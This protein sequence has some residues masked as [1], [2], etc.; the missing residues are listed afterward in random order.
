MLIAIAAHLCFGIF[1]LPSLLLL[2]DIDRKELERIA[3]AREETQEQLKQQQKEMRVRV[4][5]EELPQPEEREKPEEEKKEERAEKVDLDK[6]VVEQVTNEET[7][8]D[9]EFVSMEANKVDEE[10]RARETTLKQVLPGNEMP[11]EIEDTGSPDPDVERDSKDE[12]PAEASEQLAA[13]VP[14]QS[15]SPT[16][17]QAERRVEKDVTQKPDETTPKKVTEDGAYKV[18]EESSPVVKQESKDG[19]R[20]KVDPRKLFGPPSE[21][22]YER[23]FGE[24][25]PKPKSDGSGEKRRRLFSDYA[26]KQKKIRASLENMIPEIQPGNHTAV[27]AD[28]AVYAGYIS[29][30]HRRIH[31][32][33]AN[34]FLMTVATRFPANSPMHDPNLSTKLEFII[35]AQTGEFEEVTIVEA[36]GV[37]MFDSE[38]VATAWSIGKRPNPPPQIVSPDGN[39]YIHWTFW[40]DGRQCGVFGASVYLMQ[41]DEGGVPRRQRTDLPK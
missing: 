35:D 1:A 16:P 11:Q 37:M 9:A 33:W 40:R 6:K 22:D 38:A 34:E 15:S 24:A 7:P 29:S 31:Q 14:K 12:D 30:L 39:V 32:R 20:A 25:E 13:A 3:K 5:T 8:E 36:S 2:D 4:R 27:N 18:E 21:T 23:V 10:R 19:P 28:R 17:D 41:R 26:E